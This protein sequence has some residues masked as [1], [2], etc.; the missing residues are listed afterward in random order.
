MTDYVRVVWHRQKDRPESTIPAHRYD[1][2]KHRRTPK[3][4]VDRHGKPLPPKYRTD[5]AG[6]RPQ[7]PVPAAAAAPASG[8]PADHEGER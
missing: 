7:R 3:P 6:S 8:H 1:P 5:L 2:K 4:A